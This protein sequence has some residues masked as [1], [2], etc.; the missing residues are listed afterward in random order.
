MRGNEFLWEIKFGDRNRSLMARIFVNCLGDSAAF[1]VDI[2]EL[3]ELSSKN[4]AFTNSFLDWANM[5]QSQEYFS[6][7]TVEA[8]AREG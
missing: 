1:P 5:R 4:R 7:D 2:S 8:W 3:R 6:N